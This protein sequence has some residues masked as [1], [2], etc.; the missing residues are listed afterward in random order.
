MVSTDPG[1]W[2]SAILILCLYSIFYKEGP[3]Y[4]F[5]EHT[6]IGFSAGYGFIVSLNSL[7]DYLY[8]YWIVEQQWDTIIPVILGILMYFRYVPGKRYLQRIPLAFQ[9]GMGLGL[10]LPTM[11]QSQFVLQILGTTT[12][13]PWDLTGAFSW[14]IASVA[15]ITVI[16]Y[17]IFAYLRTPKLDPPRKIARYFLMVS[18]GASFGGC[19]LTWIVNVISRV[20]FL[21]KSWLGL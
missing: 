1:I 19:A 12:L 15:T 20:Q 11:M 6:S 21:V 8:R 13:I 5:A 16:L 4:R 10:A 14:I 17:F 2:V 9:T 3:L 18:L 7:K